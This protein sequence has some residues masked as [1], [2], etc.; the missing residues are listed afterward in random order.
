MTHA[1]DQSGDTDQHQDDG[2]QQDA[3]EREGFEQAAIVAG[4]RDEAIARGKAAADN[5]EGNR[6]QA[7]DDAERGDKEGVDVEGDAAKMR[8]TGQQHGAHHQAYG[9]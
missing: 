7:D 9:Q 4:G 8:R 2:D 5:G 1:P 6:L 3:L